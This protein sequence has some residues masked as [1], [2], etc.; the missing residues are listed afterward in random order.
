[1]GDDLTGAAPPLTAIPP[2]IRTLDDYRRHAPAHLPPA[3]W[4]HIEDVAGDGTVRGDDRRALDRWRLLPRALAGMAGASTAVDL[5]G[6][7]HAAPILLAP[8]AYQRIAHAEGELAV[9][10]A[11]AA[12]DLGLTLSTLSSVTLEEVATA[13]RAAAAEL[14][15]AAP[16]AWFQLYLQPRREDSLALV[17]RADAA[18]YGAIV[19]TIDAGIKRSEFALPPGVSAANL[20]GMPQPRHRAAPGGAILF[21]TALME[22]LP[23]WNDLA[24]LRAATR[25]PILLKGMVTGDDVD[26]AIDTGIDGLILS[27]HAGRVLDSL[28]SA[29]AMLPGVVERVGGRVPVLVDGGIRSGTDIVKALCLGARAVLIGRP[30]MHALAVAGF[31]GVAHACHL[32]RTELELAMAHL[33]CPTPADLT[34]ERLI[35]P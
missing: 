29:I 1:M 15:R 17:R 9:A 8:V 3:S 20:A 19:L 35:A 12:L 14:G 32:L 30:I 28:P 31:L 21:G 7:R 16:P 24:W 10:R 34:P 33:G 4:A 23:G 18:G 5:P 6:G 13:H 26:R 27:S 2:D 22:G 11:A 25:L